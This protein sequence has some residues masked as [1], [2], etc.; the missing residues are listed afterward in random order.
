MEAHDVL[1]RTARA[2]ADSRAERGIEGRFNLG[3]LTDE[4]AYPRTGGLASWVDK[5][6]GL[7]FAGEHRGW[8]MGQYVYE[9]VEADRDRDALF[10]MD[11]SRDDFGV[12]QVDPPFR[13]ET[14]ASVRV[15]A[16]RV[17]EGVASID[18]EIEAAGV[19]RAH[20]R[21]LLETGRRT[22]GL[23]WLL[24]KEHLTAP[25]SVYIAFPF[26][27]GEPRF[28]V[29]L[30]GVACTPDEDQ[31]NGAVR[32]WYPIRRWV[33]VS[34]GE[35]GVTLAPLDAPLV[36]LG[37]I[38]TGKAAHELRPEGSALMSW[39]LNNH[40]MVNFKASQGGEIPLR[41][42]LTTHGGACD[43][44]AANR[45]AAEEAM[46]AIVLR[47]EVRRGGGTSGRFAAVPDDLA[48]EVTAKP[49]EDGDG[50]VFRIRNL[51]PDA[52]TVP[53][54]LLAASP[55]AAWRTSPIEV[56]REPLEVAGRV[57][58]NVPPK[59]RDIAMVFQNYALY[60]HM[61]VYEN[62]A[63]A[64]K[65]RRLPR[66]QIRD[67][68]RKAAAILALME[69]LGKKPGQLSGG[70]RQ[71]VAMGRAIVREPQ[72]FLMDEPLSNLDAKLRVQMRAEIA[73]IQ[74]DLG[75]P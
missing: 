1:A 12:W 24:D 38:T 75:V 10:V 5:E 49:A 20:V 64:L 70:Q 31:L 6:L 61:S 51:G 47:D 39:A 67:N 58:N 65:L 69:Q 62:M 7:D 37:G 3:E 15:H 26:A 54:E 34:D 41:Y 17:H 59:S 33:D 25:E 53:L 27:L 8:R 73:R 74:R 2:L 13:Y 32:D 68:V 45:W 16:P 71:R 52:M 9:R 23:E 72:A 30:N 48:L 4:E 21:Y 46:P 63:F 36:Q 40:W 55:S 44:A 11:F 28:R 66:D 43:D 22:L 42:R 35:R 18:V 14:A 50:I 56:D 29:D 60:P 19:R 57:V